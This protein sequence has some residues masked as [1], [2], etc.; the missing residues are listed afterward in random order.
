LAMKRPT[1]FDK[2]DRRLWRLSVRMI[3]RVAPEPLFSQNSQKA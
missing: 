3:N 1:Q 2:T